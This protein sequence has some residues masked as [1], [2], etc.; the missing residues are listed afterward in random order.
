MEVAVV[1]DSDSGIGQAT[2]IAFAKEG[3]DVAA[4]YL[5]DKEGAEKTKGEVEAVGRKAIVLHLDQRD[6]EGVQELFHQV[7]ASLE[8]P[9]FLSMTRASTLRVNR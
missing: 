6:P 3:A 7:H 2:A 9:S 1:T 4:T 5:H 8:R